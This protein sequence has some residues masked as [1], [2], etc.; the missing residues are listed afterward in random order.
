MISNSKLKL[1]ISLNFL[2][3]FFFILLLN[4]WEVSDESTHFIRSIGS[5]FVKKDYLVDE[6]F[7]VMCKIY[8]CTISL[9]K[10]LITAF[11]SDISFQSSTV[12]ADLQNIRPYFFVSY[13]FQKLITSLLHLFLNNPLYIYFFGKVFISLIN[14]IIIY[15]VLKKIRF[16]MVKYFLIIVIN[17]PLS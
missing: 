12:T 8:D 2:F 9:Y 4:P 7:V 14:F 17:F 5:L 6:K 10:N 1:V 16:T 13:I 11:S 3:S 15:N